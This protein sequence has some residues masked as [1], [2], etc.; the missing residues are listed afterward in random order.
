MHYISDRN[1]NHTVMNPESQLVELLKKGD[2]LAFRKLVEEYQDKVYNTCLG[3]VK[4]EEEADDLSQEVFVEVFSSVHSFRGDSRLSTWIYRIAVTKSLE[5]LRSK[6]RKKRFA[7]LKSLFSAV[8]NSPVQIPNFEHPGV[9][10]ENK[11]RSLILFRAIDKLPDNQKTA[12]TLHKVEGLSYEEVGKI[13]GKTVSSVESLMHRAR[14]NLQNYLRNYYN[15][16]K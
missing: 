7:V 8:N 4:N 11:E 16:N 9:I 15:S 6:K 1:Y 13:M 14:I 12:F 5:S 2:E 10:A 3:F